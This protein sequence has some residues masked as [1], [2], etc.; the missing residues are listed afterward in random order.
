[1]TNTDASL[2]MRRF[3]PAPRSRVRLLCF[4]L[5]EDDDRPLAL[6]GHSMGALVA[7]EVARRG[8]AAGTKP[9]GLFASGRRAPSRIRDEFVHQRDD[10]GIIAELRRLNGTES[11]I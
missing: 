1:M 2:W 11:A 7:Y 3:H 6:F 9:V 4:L 5:A 8:E 10:Q